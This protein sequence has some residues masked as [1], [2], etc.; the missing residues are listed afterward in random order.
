MAE[1]TVF[2]TAMPSATPSQH[3]VVI[4]KH[5]DVMVKADKG[6][7]M[8]LSRHEKKSQKRAE[9]LMHK[10]KHVEKEVKHMS[11]METVP[12][13]NIFSSG[14]GGGTGGGALGAGLGAG[15]L[16]GV[17]GGAL[18]DG[19]LFG[20]RG[21]ADAAV[22]RGVDTLTLENAIASS[23]RLTN[24]RFDAQTQ[25]DLAL[26]ITET[27]NETQAAILTQGN[28]V[29]MEVVKAANE[30]AVQSGNIKT[31]IYRSA[32]ETQRVV[33][34]SASKVAEQVSAGNLANAIAFKDQILASSRFAAEAEIH[35]SNLANAASRQLAETNYN[36]ASAIKAEGD[37]TRGLINRIN[38]DNL[39]RQL[40]TAQNEIIEL[41]NDRNRERDSA[42]TKLQITNVNT[43]I[44]SQA[45]T[46]AQLQQQQQVNLLSGLTNS[47]SALIQQNQTI[48][49]G[50]INLGSMSGS[51]GTQ[52]NTQVR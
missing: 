17:L 26:A 25:Q 51:A 31:D 35:A 29:G 27:A 11:K 39:N 4:E 16:G 48:H 10:M 24:A 47:L 52:T 21:A 40:V 32:N 44:A 6:K 49:N 9:K 14:L 50:I 37:L 1:P 23:E 13:V 30:A 5:M 18:I 19:G 43:A 33:E 2:G 28:A 22:D 36:L 46:Q 20:R 38:D 3:P 15:L 12:D 7:G 41:R 8:T 42:E 45:Q 34:S